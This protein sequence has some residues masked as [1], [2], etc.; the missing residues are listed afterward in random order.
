MVTSTSISVSEKAPVKVN[1]DP[2]TG[3]AI[4]AI[5]D[6]RGWT[7]KEA[8]KRIVRHFVTTERVKLPRRA[9]PRGE[10]RGVSVA[11]RPSVG[12]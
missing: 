12:H 7:N 3:A 9:F 6:D 10:Q 1:C 2:D 5:A 4:V 8:L 11:R